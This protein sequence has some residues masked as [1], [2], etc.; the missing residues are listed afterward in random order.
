MHF[1][2][3]HPTFPDGVHPTQLYEAAANLAFCAALSWFYPRR[4]FDGQVFWIYA[5]LYAVMRFSIEFIRGDNPRQW[6][7]HLTNSQVTAL[8]WLVA[9]AIFLWRL[10]RTRKA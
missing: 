6:P 9:A 10:P 5:I 1:P 7:G 2:A 8:L 4:K 3:K